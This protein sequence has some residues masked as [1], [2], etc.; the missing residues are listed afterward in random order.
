MESGLVRMINPLARRLRDR[1][2]ITTMDY[3]ASWAEVESVID[4]NAETTA[5]FLFKNL[6][7]RFGFPI[8]LMSD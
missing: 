7:T 6:V 2:I 1:Y 3:L 5:R 4:C 8:I